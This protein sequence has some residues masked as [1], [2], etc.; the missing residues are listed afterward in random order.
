MARLGVI[1]L[2]AAPEAGL[3][4]QAAMVKVD[5][6]E[7]LLRC[8]EWFVNRDSVGQVVAV[9]S[10]DQAEEYKRKLASHLMILG[11]KAATGGPGWREQ[12][13]AGLEKIPADCTH[14]VVHDGARPAV[15]PL[16][17]DQLIEKADSA[18]A[19]VLTATPSASMLT[20]DESGR[21]SGIQPARQLKQLLT[22]I[23]F[24]RSVADEFAKSGFEAVLSRLTFL[25][26]SALNV[27]INGSGDAGLLKSLISQLPKPRAKSS[28]TPFEEAQW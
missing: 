1:I 10:Q 21:A 8:V 5:G 11:L 23:I 22:P 27:R 12:V 15:S 28:L 2:T 19:I 18:E 9:F 4:S 6:R 13:R 16:D 3:S 14:I 17:L 26:S 25:D 24:K 20:V 7:S